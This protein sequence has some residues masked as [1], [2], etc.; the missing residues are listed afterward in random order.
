MRQHIH[1]NQL[2]PGGGISEF[3]VYLARHS[4]HHF[5]ENSGQRKR[6]SSRGG[7]EALRFYSSSQF[8]YYESP[9]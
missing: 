7:I 2:L 9:I 6:Y 3:G 5:V 8:T 1:F 4:H